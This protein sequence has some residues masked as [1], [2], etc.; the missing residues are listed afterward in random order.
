VLAVSLAE[1]RPFRQAFVEPTI[2]LILFWGLAIWF[3]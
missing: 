3:G 2:M 1:G